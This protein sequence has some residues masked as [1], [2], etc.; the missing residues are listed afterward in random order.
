MRKI[1]TTF[2]NKQKQRHEDVSVE[3]LVMFHSNRAD[4]PR[5]FITIDVTWIHQFTPETK[6]QS[7]QWSEREESALKSR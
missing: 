2:L 6:E 7:K 4:F 1:D 5:R 3:C